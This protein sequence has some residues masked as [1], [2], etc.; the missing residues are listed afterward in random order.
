MVQFISGWYDDN[1]VPWWQSG[2]SKLKKTMKYHHTTIR[3][4]RSGTMTTSNAGKDIEQQEFSF[5][6]AGNTKWYSY[7]AR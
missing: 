3:M 6:A 5:I 2:K 7:F 1:E 4:T